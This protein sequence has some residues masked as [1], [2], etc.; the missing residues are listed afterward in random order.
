MKCDVSIVFIR[1]ASRHVQQ[2]AQASVVRD[3]FDVKYEDWCHNLLLPKFVK[4]FFVGCKAN[5]RLIEKNKS[6]LISLV[7]LGVL[8]Y[9]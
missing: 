2:G 9:P 7:W 6:M 4:T 8:L 1:C 3:S 5:E